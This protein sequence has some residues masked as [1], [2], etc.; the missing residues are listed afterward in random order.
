MPKAA[1]MST[2]VR[3]EK[4]LSGLAV[5]KSLVTSV[6]RAFLVQWWVEGRLAKVSKWGQ[7]SCKEIICEGR[8]RVQQPEGIWQK[9]DISDSGYQHTRERGND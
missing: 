1:K 8:E 3:I 9:G 7:Q 4:P 6:T 5:W 2:K